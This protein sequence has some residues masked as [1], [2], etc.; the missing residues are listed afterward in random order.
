MEK[1][2][3]SKV[4]LMS[5]I[6]RQINNLPSN[7]DVLK[8]RRILFAMLERIEEISDD[9]ENTD[10][11]YLGDL[12]T[13]PADSG[14]VQ[15]EEGKVE[16]KVDSKVDSKEFSHKEKERLGDD[17]EEKAMHRSRT[18]TSQL[19]NI[20]TYDP[21]KPKSHQSSV[22]SNSTRPRNLTFADQEEIITKSTKRET[23]EN[24]FRMSMAKNLPIVTLKLPQ[25]DQMFCDL[26]EKHFKALQFWTK[27]NHFTLI[28]DS[29]K[30]KFKRSSVQKKMFEK[31][32]IMGVIFTDDDAVFGSF[33]AATFP[34]KPK[35]AFVTVKDTQMFV[36]SLENQNRLPAPTKWKIK[37]DSPGVDWTVSLYSDKEKDPSFYNVYQCFKL[38][39]PLH[40]HNS[41]LSQDF[42]TE[43]ENGTDVSIFTGSK[44]NFAV[45]RLIF[46]EWTE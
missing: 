35:K 19:R 12:K 31:K 24:Q 8:I 1:T 46:L 13:V 15:N 10:Q 26:M 37:A 17:E 9:I 34:K 44:E 43:Y 11:K 45:K 18:K 25:K 40:A 23:T 20:T 32:N 14:T 4:S 41:T 2:Q 28:Y 39:P 3:K 42:K 36:F 21:Y 6:K 29:H 5:E 7:F 30:N 38:A 16:A 27:L 33:H 22:A